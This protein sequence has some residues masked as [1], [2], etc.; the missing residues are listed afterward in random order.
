MMT[1]QM[2]LF[3][4]DLPTAPAAVS[5]PVVSTS[6]AGKAVASKTVAGQAVA[7][8]AVVAQ[9]TANRVK[10][11]NAVPPLPSSGPVS[12]DNGSSKPNLDQ[13]RARIQRIQSPGR[14]SDGDALACFS[15]GGSVLNA[16][17]PHGGLRRG[18]IVQWV[19]GTGAATL[20]TIAASEI[21]RSSISGGKPIVI[22]D[23]SNSPRRFA[24]S[25]SI[26]SGE[27]SPFATNTFYPPAAIAL[28]IPANRMVIVT[29]KEHHTH[30]DMVWAIDQ[31]LRCDAIAAVWVEIGSW[32]D[33]RDARRL[34]LAAE[35][36][37]TVGLFIRPAEV[38]GRPSFADVNWFVSPDKQLAKSSSRNAPLSTVPGRSLSSSN[39][40]LR[41]E[42]DRCR[43]GIEGSATV[44]EI[45]S[46]VGRAEHAAISGESEQAG[47]PQQVTE[48]IIAVADSIVTSLPRKHHAAALAGDLARRLADP[49]IAKRSS[50]ERNKRDSRRAS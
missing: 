35:S 4:L 28:G 26:S 9:T 40:R 42:V 16:M 20:A 2:L 10:S 47:V 22:F 50:I 11:P 49:T 48:R 5:R 17:L 38:R 23:W 8:K 41:V 37:G 15:T 21:A 6:V 43:G 45:D 24:S 14:Q 19:G 1:Q 46:G 30:S 39:R 36:S 3:P 44:I 13:L 29:K 33:D 27:M 31:T 12:S 18:T 25:R 32:L 34:Q 7:G